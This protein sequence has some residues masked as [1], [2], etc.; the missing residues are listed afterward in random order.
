[1][2]EAI[3]MANIEHGDTVAHRLYYAHFYA[4]SAYL[5]SKNIL[6]YTHKELKLN[7]TN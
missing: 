6:R 2:Q 7:F 4:I 3:A 5:I 1:M